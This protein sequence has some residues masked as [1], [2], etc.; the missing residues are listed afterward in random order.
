[1]PKKYRFNRTQLAAYIDAF[2]GNSG[3]PVAIR[4]IEHG[5]NTHIPQRV[6][7]L[8]VGSPFAQ[9]LAAHE[10]L[11]ITSTSPNAARYLDEGTMMLLNSLEDGRMERK[12]FHKKRGL[13]VQFQRNLVDQTMPQIKGEAWIIQAIKSLYL[14]VAG[15]EYDSQNLKPR[16]RELAKKFRESGLR[17]AARAA[18]T[19][20]ELLPIVERVFPL[21]DE[22]A[23]QI[24]SR[25]R[26]AKSAQMPEIPQEGAGK[27]N[28]NLRTGGQEPRSGAQSQGVES[29]GS[30]SQNASPSPESAKTPSAGAGGVGSDPSTGKVNETDSQTYDADERRHEEEAASRMGGQSQVSESHKEINSDGKNDKVVGGATSDSIRRRA[31]SLAKKLDALKPEATLWGDNVEQSTYFAPQTNVVAASTAR[32]NNPIN[33]VDWDLENGTDEFGRVAL[34]VGSG[35]VGYDGKFVNVVP[36]KRSEYYRSS[37]AIVNGDKA[38]AANMVAEVGGYANALAMQMRTFS[39]TNAGRKHRQFARSGKLDTRRA[40]QGTLG[41]L[42]I[43]REPHIGRNGGSAFVLSVDLSGSM[44]EGAAHTTMLKDFAEEMV[45]HEASVFRLAQDW[46]SNGHK[47]KLDMAAARQE[48]YGRRGIIPPL[49]YALQSAALMSSALSRSSIAHEVHAFSDWRVG[50]AKRF[51]DPLTHETLANMW[52][53]GGGGTPAAEGL[54]VAWERLKAVDAKKRVVIQFTDG[55]V[56]ENVKDLVNDIK[57]EG[58]IVIGVGI[59]AYGV[60]EDNRRLYPEFIDCKD[61]SELPTKMASLLR[62]LTQRGI[63][64]E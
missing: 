61:P 35:K 64:G 19:T 26:K 57:R 40:S 30:T 50:I 36:V 8:P 58:G 11:H 60:D 31:R 42:D 41:K 33:K 4:D 12:S 6:V 51:N 34:S 9:D 28:P 45:K 39:Q 59:G 2:A 52:M 56:A 27:G 20:E 10:A 24:A 14:E 25:G 13:R 18:K 15:Y 21:F 46:I 5:A 62:K 49:Y 3:E 37:E 22:V 43:F 48:M 55:A 32:G 1:M 7:S 63:I 17:D 54:A 53:W 38:A 29:D 44:T 16:A 23:D 47:T